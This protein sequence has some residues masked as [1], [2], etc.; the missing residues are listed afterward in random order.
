MPKPISLP[1]VSPDFESGTIAKWHV[2]E[3]D[4]IA[5]G[6]VLVDVETDKAVVEVEAQDSGV[7]GKIMVDAGT[8]DVAVSTILG[9]LLEEGEGI[10][11]LADIALEDSASTPAPA[12]PSAQPVEPTIT[13]TRESDVAQERIFASPLARRIAKQKGISLEGIQ[14]RG[15]NGRILKADLEGVTSGVDSG[16]TALFSASTKR[17]ERSTEIPL[18]NMRRT[19]ARRLSESKQT[20]P[21][22]TLSVD[23]ELDPLLQMRSDINA[24]AKDGNFKLSVNDF[25]IKACALALSDVPAVNTSWTNNAILQHHNADIS[26]AVATPNGLITPII[27]DA[28]KKSIFQISE[29]ATAL[30]EKAR[31]G[32]LKPAEF[33]GGTFSISNLGM[34]GTKHFTAIINPPQSCILAVG[35]GIQQPVVKDGE[36]AIAT[37]LTATLSSDHRTVDGAIA[38]QFMQS[39]KNRLERP[40]ALLLNS[41]A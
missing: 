29:E 7:L 9:Y 1:A 15:P 39:L 16:S 5:A 14:G 33:Q 36:L 21:H 38:A 27:F 32:R 6:D 17:T 35:A 22:F 34:F 24:E 25:V 12:S 23:I 30:A 37:V 3:G 28:D 13:D 18:S 2:A 11:S 26:V 10:E 19:I 20:I 40:M 4:V 31:A 8:D 41:L